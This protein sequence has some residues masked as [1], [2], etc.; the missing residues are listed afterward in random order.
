MSLQIH[1]ICPSMWGNLSRKPSPT[2]ESAFF[3]RNW[4]SQFYGFWQ[5][6]KYLNCELRLRS[7]LMFVELRKWQISGRIH[8]SAV[9]YNR[10]TSISIPLTFRILHKPVITNDMKRRFSRC[11]YHQE[12]DKTVNLHSMKPLPSKPFLA[13]SD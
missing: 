9:K 6:M 13:Q 12:I 1:P 5:W 7:L 10:I 8:R 4:R 3:S 2:L 11:F